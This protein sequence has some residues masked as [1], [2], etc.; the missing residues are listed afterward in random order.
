MFPAILRHIEN[1]LSPKYA[2][3]IRNFAQKIS[4]RSA[5]FGYDNE[6]ELF[7]AKDLGLKRFFGERAR[8]FALYT[9]GLKFRSE[10][11][12]E[13]YCLSEVKIKNSDVIVD[14][15]ANFGDL[16]LHY[17][18]SG[19]KIKYF[20]FEPAPREFLALQQNIPEG[21]LFNLGL[22]DHVGNLCFYLQSASADSSFIEP[23]KF[24]SK[25]KVEVVTLDKM[26]QE[27]VFPKMV[28]LFKLEAEGYEPE[29]LKGAKEFIKRC[30]YIAIDGGPER[31]INSEET[32]SFQAQFLI[33]NGFKLISINFSRGSGLFV[34]DNV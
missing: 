16:E 7:F 28:K 24:T 30:E 1:K 25:I 19:K 22:S 11:L 8:G 21:N 31:G 18:V 33:D 3:I 6:T 15:G 17:K 20:G 32:F 14:C 5:R 12:I 29:I 23:E 4:G 27:G 9:R 2:C 13:S 34:N 10:Q 26:A